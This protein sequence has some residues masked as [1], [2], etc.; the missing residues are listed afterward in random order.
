MHAY[1]QP[2]PEFTMGIVNGLS[3]HTRAREHAKERMGDD[4]H[5]LLSHCNAFDA[6]NTL[7][8][9]MHTERAR[10]AVVFFFFFF[11]LHFLGW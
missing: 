3:T 8:R 5:E 10:V 7:P 4:A 1:T 11:L 6:G 9:S 2:N